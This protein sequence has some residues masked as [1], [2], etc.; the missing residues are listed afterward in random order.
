[1]KVQL[2]DRAKDK[3]LLEV[4]LFSKQETEE[5]IAGVMY[6]KRTKENEIIEWLDPVLIFKTNIKHAAYDKVVR[7]A[8]NAGILIMIP[9]AKNL[10]SDYYGLDFDG[11][12]V[13]VKSWG[14]TSNHLP[15]NKRWGKFRMREAADNWLTD[16]IL[17]AD[18]VLFTLSKV[19]ENLCDAEVIKL[20][21]QQFKGKNLIGI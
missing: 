18:V 15:P 7:L 2:T 8:E 17:L 3:G 10:K 1:M 11:H 9:E 14:Y 20:I 21:Q 12:K 4:E 5:I 16:T 13:F 19:N 6:E